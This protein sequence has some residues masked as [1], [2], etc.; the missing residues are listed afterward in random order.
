M[1]TV[2]TARILTAVVLYGCV[3][4]GVG[5]GV[6][7]VV[8]TLPMVVVLVLVLVAGGVVWCSMI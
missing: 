4:S 3:V 5:G 7:G 2:F 1:F 6:V 8:S